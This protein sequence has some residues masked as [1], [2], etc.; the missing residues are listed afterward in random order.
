M[1][2]S[3][4]I[5]FGRRCS[6]QLDIPTLWIKEEDDDEQEASTRNT[7]R[8][9][10][11]DASRHYHTR[12]LR[13]SL[14]FSENPKRRRTSLFI[15]PS[16][17]ST[18]LVASP[19]SPPD[20]SNTDQDGIPL[21]VMSQMN[22]ELPILNPIHFSRSSTHPPYSQTESNKRKLLGNI[23]GHRKEDRYS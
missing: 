1:F 13:H 19:I 4:A 10:L 11:F 23:V 18:A 7:R 15:S 9:S 5:I 21:R 14:P 22:H 16:T 17:A 3:A 6:S 8:P 20:M 2:N 12:R